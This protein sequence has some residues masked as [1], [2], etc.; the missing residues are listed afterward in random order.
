MGGARTVG[1][2]G[3]RVHD[4]YHRRVHDPPLGGQPAVITLLVRRFICDNIRWV[5]RTF[6]ERF[7]QPTSPHARCTRRL[8]TWMEVIGPALA[9]RAGSRLARSLG[10]VAGRMTFVRRVLALPGPERGVPRVLG[11]DD[12]ATRRGATYATVITSGET[13]QVIDVL[14]G[15]GRCPCGGLTARRPGRSPG[16]RPLP[17]LAG[18]RPGRGEDRRSPP[19][20]LA[21][22]GPAAGAGGQLWAHRTTRR[23]QASCPR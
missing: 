12:F 2:A 18:P 14:P 1:G 6:A 9:G 5:R 13:H 7:T 20:L 22:T 19:L 21:G 4:R 16:R 11:V 8:G 3:E 15:P 23:A 17:P 10:I